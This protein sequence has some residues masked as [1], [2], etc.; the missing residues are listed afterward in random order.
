MIGGAHEPWFT[1]DERADGVVVVTR[2]GV[3]FASIA[4]VERGYGAAVERL[5]RLPRGRQSVLVD[6]RHAPPRNDPAF[7]AAV[8]PLRR[9][10]FAG[11]ASCGVVVRSLVGKMQIQRHAAEDGHS[12]EVFTDLPV[13]LR[14]LARP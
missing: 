9:R 12:I 3:P 5:E 4:E 7:E 6:L 1:I 11:F 8:A 10:I 2:S 13:A 14:A